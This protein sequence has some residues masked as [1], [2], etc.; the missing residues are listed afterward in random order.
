[1]T[2][3]IKKAYRHFNAF[4]QHY[5][6]KQSFWRAVQ[7]K[8]NCT[9]QTYSTLK[10][11]LLCCHRPQDWILDAFHWYSNPP[12]KTT[13]TWRDLD[14]LWNEYSHNHNYFI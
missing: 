4:L 10:T 6:C 2:P 3:R 1:M 7:K 8:A 5:Q 12:D 13:L 14:R 9:K 11:K